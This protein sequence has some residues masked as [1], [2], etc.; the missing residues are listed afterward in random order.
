MMMVTSFAYDAAARRW[1]HGSRAPLRGSAAVQASQAGSQHA[2]QYRRTT[3]YGMRPR[4]T[5]LALRSRL[6]WPTLSTGISF[7]KFKLVYPARQLALLCQ[8][9]CRCL[10][11]TSAYWACS[12]RKRRKS[13]PKNRNNRPL[14]GALAAIGSAASRL[15]CSAIACACDANPSPHHYRNWC[16]NMAKHVEVLLTLGPRMA[17]SASRGS[18]PESRRLR[19]PF[20]S[21]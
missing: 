18:G 5:R 15:M 12:A 10:L 9:L 19:L 1:L 11:V 14:R 3:A 20:A 6:A 13:R 8:P 4:L 2:F 16:Q 17:H 7:R 21:L